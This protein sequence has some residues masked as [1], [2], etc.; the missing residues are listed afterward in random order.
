VNT[1]LVSSAS[2]TF[3]LAIGLMF[4]IKASVKDRI[5]KISFAITEPEEAFLAKLDQYLVD[6]AYK[7]VDISD[8]TGVTYEGL[9]APSWFM[10]IF[11]TS[12]AAGGFLCL[13]LVLNYI[14]TSNLFLV[15]A[16]LAPLAGLFYWKKSERLEQI[17]FI[18]TESIPK[19]FQREQANG[20][21]LSLTGHRDELK[22]L[23]RSLN[24]QP[25]EVD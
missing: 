8:T 9:V 1:V 22:I 23:E 18:A 3:L 25:T 21:M 14:F 6:R 17:V 20:K 16:I 13:G 7:L 15:L 11:L 2:L 5:E 19:N 12:L 10:A 4:F 24:I